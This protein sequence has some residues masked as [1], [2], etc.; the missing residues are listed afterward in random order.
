MPFLFRC[1]MLWLPL[2]IAGFSCLNGSAGGAEWKTTLINEM[3]YVALEEFAGAFAMKPAKRRKGS[4]EIGFAGESHQLVVKTGTR[5]VIVDGV[6]HWLS[7]PA[8]KKGGQAFISLM[9]INATL[10][11]AMSPQT[12]KA[13]GKVNT[14]VFDPGHGGHDLGGK[15]AYG[16][17]KDYTLDM[18]NR[19]RRILEA[20]RVKVVQSRL[21]DAFVNLS[22][23]PK[24]IENYDHPI[25]VSVHFNSAEWKPSANGIE[26]YAM[27]PLGFPISG[28]APDPILDRQKCAGNASEPASFVLANTMHHTLLGK[29]GGFDRGVKRARYAVLRHSDV[30]SILIECAFLTNSQ[31]AGNV[32]NPQWREMFAQAMAD[33][34]LAYMGLANKE[35]LP[36]RAGD[37]GRKSTDEFIWEE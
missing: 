14:V 26:V 36:A 32:H 31:E 13:I 34:I 25:F 21:S 23:R 8:E 1:R 6:R 27:P 20:K 12:V 9:D 11:P 22:E 37:F 30:P 18:V 17:E 10:V 19:A 15:S 28:K 5:E 33:G 3:G 29:T 2:V 16:Y 24:M 35:V 7:F 4:G